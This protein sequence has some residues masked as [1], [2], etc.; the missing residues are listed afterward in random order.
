MLAVASCDEV[1]RDAVTFRC[2][3]VEVK[4]ADIGREVL[5]HFDDGYLFIQ[6]TAGGADNV[7]NQ[8]G[9]I[10]CQVEMTD[11]ALRLVQ[12]VEDPTCQWRRSMQTTLDINRTSS[13]FRFQQEGC[14]P[15]SDM[16][17][18]G[19]CASWTPN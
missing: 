15:V 8:N 16:V 3:A 7:C 13:V 14:D 6:N 10:S 1:N 2:Q 12:I 5:F 11:S 9:T 19:S 4:N 17:I 18:E